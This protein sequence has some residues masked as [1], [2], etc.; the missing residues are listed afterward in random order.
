[1]G[2]LGRKVGLVTLQ[3]GERLAVGRHDAVQHHAEVDVVEPAERDRGTHGNSLALNDRDRPL[4]GRCQ[5]PAKS[6]EREKYENRTDGDR[7]AGPRPSGQEEIT[8]GAST[9]TGS[10]GSPGTEPRCRSASGCCSASGSPIPQPRWRH[11]S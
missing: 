2:D 5:N 4:R 9:P 8:G 11:E 7:Y 6:N 1:I 3:V 10:T